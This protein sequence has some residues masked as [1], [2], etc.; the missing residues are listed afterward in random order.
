[1]PFH[2]MQTPLHSIQ[3]P[4]PLRQA[5]SQGQTWTPL[6]EHKVEMSGVLWREGWTPSHL[7]LRS[8]SM[9]CLMGRPP[10]GYQSPP[11]LHLTEHQ[12]PNLVPLTD[13]QRLLHPLTDHLRQVLS[14]RTDLQKPSLPTPLL[15]QQ[16]HLTLHLQPPP[17]RPQEPPSLPM[18]LRPWRALHMAEEECHT[19]LTMPLLPAMVPAL[20][21]GRRRVAEGQWDSFN[22][23][24]PKTLYPGSFKPQ[25]ILPRFSNLFIFRI[26]QTRASRSPILSLEILVSR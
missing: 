20:Q 7:H 21:P 14:P 22:W 6:K 23:S 13:L 5:S 12:S 16:L 8:P 4:P 1:M 2:L 15:K 10:Q 9:K 17:T 26:K 11:H 3:D 24:A 25:N 19:P 18:A